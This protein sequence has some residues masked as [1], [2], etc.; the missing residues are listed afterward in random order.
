MRQQQTFKQIMIFRGPISAY[1][2]VDEPVERVLAT[3]SETMLVVLSS[4]TGLFH[5]QPN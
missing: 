5:V 1:I 4:S 2:Y 3:A